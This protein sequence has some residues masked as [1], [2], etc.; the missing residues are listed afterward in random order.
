[1]AR[2]PLSPRSLLPASSPLL[3]CVL[4]TMLDSPHAQHFPGCTGCGCLWAQIWMQEGP[5]HA[6]HSIIIFISP[7]L[8]AKKGSENCS[9][10]HLC[11]PPSQALGGVE[12]YESGN[13]WKASRV[14]PIFAVL[15]LPWPSDIMG[16][17]PRHFRHQVVPAVHAPA[18]PQLYHACFRPLPSCTSE[19]FLSAPCTAR[20]FHSL[21]RRPGPSSTASARERHKP[22]TSARR[23]AASRAAPLDSLGRRPA[24][25]SPPGAGWGGYR[26][27]RF[28]SLRCLIGGGEHGKRSTEQLG[29]SG[30]SRGAS[31]G[32]ESGAAATASGAAAWRSA[33]RPSSGLQMGLR[34][35]GRLQRRP[36]HVRR[37]CRCSALCARVF[38]H[39]VGARI[40]GVVC[41]CVCARH[42]A[43]SAPEGADAASYSRAGR[44][45]A[46]FVA[47]AYNM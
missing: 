13:Q 9:A 8:D 35:P 4:P 30:G 26:S 34:W 27:L 12:K 25:R 44:S 29:G 3:P 14:V 19:H 28:D 7:T 43:G 40:A 20:R 18:L 33:T 32:G 1:M 10:P 46:V 41:A 16:Q 6:G 22:P 24:M 21:E 38:A 17:L 31:R 45:S 36:A 47:C 15:T 39:V 37:P 5:A 23:Q 11:P 2:A 42:P